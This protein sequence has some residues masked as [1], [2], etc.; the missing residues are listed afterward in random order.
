MLEDFLSEGVE[1]K[2]WILDSRLRRGDG[3]ELSKVIRMFGGLPSISAT[4]DGGFTGRQRF[5]DKL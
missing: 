3:D 4:A 2:Y 1:L 5:L